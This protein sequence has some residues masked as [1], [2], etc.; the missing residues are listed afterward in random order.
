MREKGMSQLDYLWVNFGNY[1]VQNE[2]SSSPQ[3]NVILSE[4]AVIQLIQNSTSKGIASL[5]YREHPSKQDTMQLIGLS[6]DGNEIS[7]VEIPKEIHVENFTHRKVTQTDI[8]NGC[9]FPIDSSVISITL[10]NKVEY[11]VSLYELGLEL[12]GNSTNSIVTEINN[13]IISANLKINEAQNTS[14]GVEL[15]KNEAG[16]YGNLILNTEETGI[17]LSIDNGKLTA[18]LPLKN[19]DYNLNFQQLTLAEYQLIQTKSPS[20]VYIISDK[21]YIYIGTQRYGVDMQPGEVPIVSLT[22]DTTTMTLSYKKSDGSDTQKIV[23]GPVTSDTPGMITPDTYNDIVKLRTA[24]D[25]IISIKDYVATEVNKAG[26][27]LELGE[28]SNG[29][30]PLNLKDNTGKII[31]SVNIDVENFV[32]FGTSKIAD[33][34]DVTDSGNTV[35]EGHYILILTLTSGEKVYIDLNN[36]TSNIKISTEEDNLL[37]QDDSGLYAS[38]K[39][40]KV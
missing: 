24:L 35:T 14:H 39:W 28:S 9:K 30:K 15:L 33:S 34:Q 5:T 17:N 10:S 25:D 23:L 3:D 18:K 8:D 21:P 32:E 22:Y 37:S 19:T 26:F 31:S 40:I 38:L 2:T 11:L 20:T 6:T 12:Q 7:I 1:S 29:Y 4:N 36:V 13:G 27:S 16:V